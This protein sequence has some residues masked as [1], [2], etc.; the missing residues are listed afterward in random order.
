M[1]WVGVRREISRRFMHWIVPGY[2]KLP[3]TVQDGRSREEQV[4]RC[5]TYFCCNRSQLP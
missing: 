1:G 2:T 3:R 4:M 5:D